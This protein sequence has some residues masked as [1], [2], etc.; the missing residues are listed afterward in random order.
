VSDHQHVAQHQFVFFP[1]LLFR[2][3]SSMI[4]DNRT[5]YYFRAGYGS[6][7]ERFSDEKSFVTAP[8]ASPFSFI[9]GGDVGTEP[10]SRIVLS[11]L[12]V[13]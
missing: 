13:A 8:D 9:V 4:V 10:A 6:G 11:F 7:V 1:V 12:L 5:A 2:V 3:F